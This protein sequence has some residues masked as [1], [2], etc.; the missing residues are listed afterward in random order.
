MEGELRGQGTRV[1][2]MRND[3]KILVGKPEGKRSVLRFGHING[4][5]KRELKETPWEDAE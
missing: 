5:I 4:D 1:V 2:E 3:Y